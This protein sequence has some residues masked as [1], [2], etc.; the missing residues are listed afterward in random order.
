M[1]WEGLEDRLDRGA[2]PALARER[3]V[4]IDHVEEL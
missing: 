3:A 4:E 1:A 2:V